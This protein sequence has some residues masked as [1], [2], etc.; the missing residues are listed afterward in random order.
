MSDKK[1]IEARISGDPT[2]QEDL[3]RRRQRLAELKTQ[4]DSK[5]RHD[6]EMGQRLHDFEKTNGSEKD[7]HLKMEQTRKDV[8]DGKAKM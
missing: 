3:F 4:Y 7:I 5:K 6:G 2:E 1:N 8:E